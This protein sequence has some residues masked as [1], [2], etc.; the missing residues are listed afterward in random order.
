MKIYVNRIIYTYTFLILSSMISIANAA[1][2]P[3]LWYH[4]HGVFEVWVKFAPNWIALVYWSLHGPPVSQPNLG[5]YTV[6]FYRFPVNKP[7]ASKNRDKVY[8]IG[9]TKTSQSILP[10]L[11]QWIEV[12]LV[13]AL[14]MGALPMIKMVF[15]Q[16]FSL[17]WR[18]TSMKLSWHG[19]GERGWIRS[20]M[21]AF[22]GMYF[23][24]ISKEMHPVWISSILSIRLLGSE[25][26]SNIRHESELGFHPEGLNVHFHYSIWS[27]WFH[28]N[29]ILVVKLDR[30]HKQSGAP[31]SYEQC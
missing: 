21:V 5:K 23:K 8:Q 12:V 31:T 17:N 22:E 6:G 24:G 16:K 15:L 28:P 13:A 4:R 2:L 19:Y 20:L 29:W 11:N 18:L 27:W 10:M 9:I 14:R 7:M 1:P 25:E 3:F 26:N 30:L